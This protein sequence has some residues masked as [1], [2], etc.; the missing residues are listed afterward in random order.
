MNHPQTFRTNSYQR[1]LRNQ[2]RFARLQMFAAPLVMVI[3]GIPAF[4]FYMANKDLPS[5]TVT[6]EP[7]IAQQVE[8]TE[9]VVTQTEAPQPEVTLAEV[10]E[11]GTTETDI[12]LSTPEQTP[13]P[14]ATVAE[15]SPEIVIND[16]PVADP[17]T[18]S[19]NIPKDTTKIPDAPISDTPVVQTAS[20]QQEL[21]QLDPDDP[22]ALQ[23]KETYD[24]LQADI[25]Q[26]EELLETK[27]TETRLLEA[28]NRKSI[29]CVFTGRL[30]RR[31]QKRT[32]PGKHYHCSSSRDYNLRSRTSLRSRT[33]LGSRTSLC[34][35]SYSSGHTTCR[36]F[37]TA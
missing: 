10:S 19:K 36:R 13:V 1:S 24:A 25:Q 2:K 30:C 4:L 23:L 18:T 12:P 21:V 16:N 20:V 22:V 34:C 29:A 33:G 5:Q 6:A 31:Q 14:G 28:G 27:R 9:P 11:N 35:S 7:Q 17:I 8:V 37:V 3:L 32:S 15:E 26:G